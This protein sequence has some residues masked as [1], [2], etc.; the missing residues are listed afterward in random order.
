[1]G[2]KRPV[3]RARLAKALERLL[4]RLAGISGGYLGG[5]LVDAEAGEPGDQLLP[6]FGHVVPAPGNLERFA[7]V[8]W[9]DDVL[10]CLVKVKVEIEW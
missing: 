9:V 2:R 5:H 3:G 4:G 10:Q 7:E 6:P 1:M 8:A